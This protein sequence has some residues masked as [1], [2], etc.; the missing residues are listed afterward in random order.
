[1]IPMWSFWVKYHI[2]DVSRPYSRCLDMFAGLFYPFINFYGPK[3][4][5]IWQTWSWLTEPEYHVYD[6][7]VFLIWSFWA[8]YHIRG[9][10]R[11]YSRCL[12]MFTG[13][14]HPFINFYGP[15]CPKISQSWS[16]LTKPEYHVY[17]WNVIL[18]WSF[19]T[20]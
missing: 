15:K 18:M 3:F 4:P 5:K 14:F 1:M 17:D 12:D 10:S 13:L 19:W 16:W 7:N 9:V 11:P 8:K 2:R 6:R 20:K